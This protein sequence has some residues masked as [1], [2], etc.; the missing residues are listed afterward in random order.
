MLETTLSATPLPSLTNVP[1]LLSS[2]E[3]IRLAMHRVGDRLP[4]GQRIGTMTNEQLASVLRPSGEKN[5]VIPY[6]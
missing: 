4:V 2:I 1:S 5:V 6:R 3:T